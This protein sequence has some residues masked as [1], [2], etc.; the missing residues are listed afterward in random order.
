M[1][2]L[3]TLLL[4]TIGVF[5]KS[6]I[7]FSQ[8]AVIYASPTGSALN[9]GSES[10]P[11][12][13]Q[14][15]IVQA[16]SNNRKHVRLFSGTYNINSK[17]VVG[18]DDL[19]I[20]GDWEVNAGVGQKN[21]SLTTVVNIDSPLEVDNYDGAAGTLVG[22]YIGIEAIATNN[23]RIQDIT[24][25]VKNG[26]T[27][28]VATGTTG[29]RGTSVYGFYFRNSNGWVLE[30]CEMN[31]G[32]GSQGAQGTNSIASTNGSNAGNGSTGDCDDD[33]ITNNGGAGGWGAGSVPAPGVNI[34]PSCGST[35]GP[36]QSGAAGTSA[37]V[38]RSGG[39]GGSGGTAGAENNAGG[40]GGSGGNGGGG[41]PGATTGGGAG[42]GYGSNGG[43]N[44]TTGDGRAGANGVNGTP[45]ANG[46]PLAIS[47]NYNFFWEPS[48]Q[49]STGLDGAGGSG[50]RGGGGG[51]GQGCFFCIDGT[52]SAG[53]GGGGGG[54]G[55]LGAT[56]GWGAG[57]TFALYQYGGN[58]TRNN[59]ILNSGPLAVGG[60]GG[61]GANG[62]TGGNGG[63]GGG[64]NNTSTT[65]GC[66]ITGARVCG[67]SE[68]GAGG[69]GGNGGNGGKGGDGGAGANGVTIPIQLVGGATAP[70]S[71]TPAISQVIANK[72]LEGCTNSEIIITKD[73]GTWTLTG[74]GAYIQ[75]LSASTST[76]TN[77]SPSALVS[78]STTGAQ[79]ITI[80]GVDYDGFIMVN[81]N[82][83]LP[84]FH[85]SMSNT[86]CEGD[87]FTMN[88]PTSGAEYEWVIF[89][90]SSNTASPTAIFTTS[91]ASWSTPI[92]GVSTNYSVRLRIRENCCGWSAPVYF[93]FSVVTTTVGPVAVGASICEN[94]TATISATGTGA[95]NLVWYSD[96]LGQIVLQSTAGATSSYTTDP[97]NQTTVFYV[98]ESIGG[99]LSALTSVN[100]AVAPAPLTPTSVNVS[101]CEGSFVSIQGTG[102]GTGDLVFSD[103]AMLT[104][105]TVPMTTGA[106][107][108][109]NLGIL[110]AGTYTYFVSENNGTCTSDAAPISVVVNVPVGNP[111]ISIT[112]SATSICDGS[113]VTF[114]ASS[115]NGGSNPIYQ[116]FLN[117]APVGSDNSVFATSNLVNGDI[118][119]AEITSDAFCLVSSTASS[120]TIS[121][122]VNPLV[123]PSISITASATSICNGTAVTFTATSSNGGTTPIYDWFVNGVSQATNATTFVSSTLI[124]GDIVSASMVSD[125]SCASPM[126][127]GSN[128]ISM[129]VNSSLTPTISIAAS[130]LI[131][132]NGESVTFT[133]SIV[134]G[135]SNPII[136]WFVNGSPV[137]TS[138]STF[139]SSTIINGDLVTAQLTSD[140]VCVTSAVAL[141]N[142][143]NM[144]V[145][146]T[147]NPTISVV[148]SSTT[149]CP[150][151]NVTFTAT[152]SNGGAGPIY[153]WY[154]NGVGQGV[155]ATSFSSSSLVNGEV[156]TASLTSN[157]PCASISFA[158]SNSITMVVNSSLTPTISIAASASTICSGESVTFTASITN[159]GANPVIQ[160]FVNGSSVGSNNST[161]TTTIVSN[162]DVISA[163]LTSDL[164]CATPASVTSG[165]IVMNV[166]SSAVP[167]AFIS[168]PQTIFCAGQSITITSITTNGGTTPGYDWYLNGVSTGVTTANYT[169][170]AFM[171]GDVI[172]LLFTSSS[173]CASPNQVVSNSITMI[174]SSS[175]I[176][177]VS[178]SSLNGTLCEDQSVTFIA[179]PTNAT[180]NL[181]YQWMVNGVNV[182]SNSAAFATSNLNAGDQVSLVLTYDNACGVTQ[183][184]TSNTLTITAVPLV[185]AGTDLEIFSGETVQLNGQTS[186]VG[187]YTWSPSSFLDDA[188]ILN[189]IGS[190]TITIEYLLSV[191]T[192]DGC[193]GSDAVIVTVNSQ[194]V[195]VP[196][197]FTPNEDGTNDVW[198]IANIELYPSMNLQIFNR[199]GNLIYEQTNTYVPWDGKF[200]GKP[201]PSETYFFILK[202]DESSD[203][204][205]GPITIVR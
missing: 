16:C 182:G 12:D 66:A 18:C 172:S 186:I 67:N 156:V 103:N 202:L 167:M 25:N 6:T 192:A 109:H 178:I 29:F 173:N 41:A 106:N 142:T 8:C 57:G 175:T 157:S 199:W 36:G 164:S 87:N 177:S 141:S 127:I 61:I 143:L 152:T 21:S 137:G 58:G 145:N 154:I 95:G 130:D 23:L 136:Q 171:N 174:E 32:A 165:N 189:P 155:N 110:T 181:V 104:L 47:S 129:S 22:Y 131:I 40:S 183:T 44:C 64:G 193:T 161:F 102:S 119:T 10:N 78:Y 151:T 1:K 39:G 184:A 7:S 196:N 168:T 100:V 59:T 144:V 169:S 90:A 159:G 203:A 135:G 160:W 121:M 83:P 74:S 150:G 38:F 108:T 201:L 99:C 114:T 195:D 200:K 148:A 77:A 128:A 180:S 166:E 91:V 33:C 101:A 4:F 94:D 140:L 80:N 50:G 122:V 88:T 46:T 20:D 162:G 68:V 55:G 35:S 75:N 70:A 125:V 30:R 43:G 2:K 92:T 65:T 116:W 69:R 15:A 96:A 187:A 204:L 52:G 34:D 97:L 81:T 197:S 89:N 139:T 176:A 85:S 28:G 27:S 205:K 86:I 24:F 185:N 115:T 190:S 63:L 71:T 62:G 45:G 11:V 56:G 49:S 126:N 19:I 53:G 42:A 37:G 111:T 118:V 9:D 163:Q 117:G 194:D 5:L 84:T 60:I 123:T 112:A 124:N 98:S 26:G 132:C 158:N 54:Q 198:N 113:N 107:Q 48:G 79:S 179:T 93:N 31:T 133:A 73:G 188:N 134:N 191:T 138:N 105:A 76:Y 147:V 3:F 82:R 146:T 17:I 153:E 149:I 72:P 14:T 13:L 51:G 120:N 170:T